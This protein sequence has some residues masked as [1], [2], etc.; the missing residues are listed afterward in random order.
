MYGGYLLDSKS[1]FSAFKSDDLGA[2]IQPLLVKM[3]QEK[4]FAGYRDVHQFATEHG[5]T[6]PLLQ[7]VKTVAYRTSVTVTN[8]RNG[9]VLPQTFKL[10]A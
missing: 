10:D 1:I 3:D 6:I 4:R 7:T 8:Y 9:W 5:Y 2:K